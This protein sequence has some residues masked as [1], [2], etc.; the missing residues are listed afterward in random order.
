VKENELICPE[1]YQKILEPITSTL[2]QA[3]WYDHRKEQNFQK[4]KK[5][6]VLCQ[7]L[8]SDEEGLLSIWRHSDA[9][10]SGGITGPSEEFE[11][12]AFSCYLLYERSKEL[13][14]TFQSLT[15]HLLPVGQGEVVELV[16]PKTG[17]IPEGS[18]AITVGM[19]KL[20]YKEH[21]RDRRLRVFVPEQHGVEEVIYV[22]ADLNQAR[23]IYSYEQDLHRLH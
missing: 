4:T 9:I 18:Y 13:G 17:I 16:N 21:K 20:A 22:F 6:S 10:Y 15:F 11:H 3:V 7:A 23:T 19:E 14:H 2:D 5:F 12:F 8:V 1:I